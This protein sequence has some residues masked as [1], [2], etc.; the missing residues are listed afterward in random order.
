MIPALPVLS[1]VDDRAVSIV[2]VCSERR[3]GR[4]E[5]HR[6]DAE[7]ARRNALRPDKLPDNVRV[8]MIVAAPETLPKHNGRCRIALRIAASEEPAEHRFDADR[9]KEMFIDIDRVDSDGTSTAADRYAVGP[10]GGN[11]GKGPAA[12]SD[13][14]QIRQ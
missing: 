9:R 5:V 11:V 13:V 4:N 6:H 8:A 12:G 1:V 2:S 10:V 3:E 7:D 14:A